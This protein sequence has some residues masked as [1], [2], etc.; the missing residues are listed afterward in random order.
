MANYEI[1]CRIMSDSTTEPK[2]KHIK[3][4]GYLVGTATTQKPVADIRKMIDAGDTFFTKSPSTGKIA[5]VGKYTCEKCNKYDSIRSTGDVV[6]DNNVDNL[7]N[8]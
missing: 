7:K 4:V 2:H 6:Q 8:C 3:T 5:K 1:V